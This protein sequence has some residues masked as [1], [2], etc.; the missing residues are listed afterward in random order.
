MGCGEEE[1]KNYEELIVYQKAYKLA[2][3]IYRITHSGLV[4][5]IGGLLTNL[6]RSLK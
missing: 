1:M 3:E 2:L 4:D 5:D 6:T